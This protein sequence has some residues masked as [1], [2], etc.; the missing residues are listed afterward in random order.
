MIAATLAAP[1]RIEL[2][3]FPK[4][5]IAE[6]TTA[7]VR[8]TRAGICGSDLCSAISPGRSRNPSPSP[9]PT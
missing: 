7:L 2:K 8:I 5:E 1:G 3:E 6:S 9:K 4:P